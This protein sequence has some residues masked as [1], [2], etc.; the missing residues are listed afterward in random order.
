MGSPC[1]GNLNRNAAN[2]AAAT[3]DENTFTRFDLCI[4]KSL[5]AQSLHFA[6]LVLRL[7]VGSEACFL[8][9]VMLVYAFACLIAKLTP[10]QLSIV[11]CNLPAWLSGKPG[12]TMQ[13][14]R[15]RRFR[16]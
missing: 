16:G 4:F 8:S 7:L 13:L 11:L 6:M 1:L 12:V 10:L 14:D 3:V 15:K 5:Q 9:A 2:S